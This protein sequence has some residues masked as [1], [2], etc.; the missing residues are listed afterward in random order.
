MM[1]NNISKEERILIAG[2]NGMAGSAIVRSL[3]RAGY[4]NINSN[5]VLL[6]PSR[7]ELNLLNP[8]EV[9][10]WFEIKISQH[11]TNI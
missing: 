4:G 2:S 3:K 1:T 9:E 11:S 6:T 8:I 5:G 10:D 7:N